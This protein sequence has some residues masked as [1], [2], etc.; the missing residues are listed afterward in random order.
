[1]QFKQSTLNPPKA[2]LMKTFFLFL[3]SLPF[4]AFSQTTYLPQG[5]K[6]NILLE[7][8]EIKARNRFHSQL[9]KNKTVQ[10]PAVHSAIEQAGFN[11][12]SI[13]R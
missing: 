9:F 8:L 1:M 3:I 4:V 13:K 11:C 7:R 12:Q 6:E 2:E 10:P 5:A